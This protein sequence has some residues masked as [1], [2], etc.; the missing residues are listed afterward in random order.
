M[1]KN[2]FLWYQLRKPSHIPWTRKPGLTPIT[3]LIRANLTAAVMNLLC[4]PYSMS[5]KYE[6]IL[7]GGKKRG[8]KNTDYIGCRHCLRQCILIIIFEK[9]R[10][11][12][13]GGESM[14]SDKLGIHLS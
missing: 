14:E 11:Q 9:Q 12:E 1:I 4:N 6:L 10:E 3:E 7:I 13:G 5:Y 8:Q 2:G